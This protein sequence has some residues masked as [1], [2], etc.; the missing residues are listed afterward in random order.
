[1]G[2]PDPDLGER[3]CLC[4]IMNEDADLSMFAM[5]EYAKGR[6]EK[7]K[8]PDLVMRMDEFPRLG[9]GKIDKKALQAH[10]KGILCP[11]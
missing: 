11:S 7:C 6:I 9:N 2:Y 4:V 3:T 1:M 10:V 8:I 5:R